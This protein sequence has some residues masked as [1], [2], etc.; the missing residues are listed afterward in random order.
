MSNVDVDVDVPTSDTEK[1]SK[2]RHNKTV[3]NI[4]PHWYT[5]MTSGST[6]N[7]S[8]LEWQINTVMLVLK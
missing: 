2:R 1:S 3:V 5:F 8:T 7:E 4:S 6:H